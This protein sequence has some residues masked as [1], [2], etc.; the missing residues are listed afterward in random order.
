M[1]SRYSWSN[2]LIQRQ[3]GA[4]ASQVLLDLVQAVDQPVDLLGDGV[5][6]EARARGRG[7]AEAS[8]QR[9]GAVVAGADGD[10]LPVED[11]RDVVRMDPGD[12]ERDDPGTPLDG[13]PEDADPVELGELGQRVLGQLVLVPLDRVEADLVEVVDRDAEAVGLRN[14]GCAGLELVRQ[15]VPAR[16]VE[17][18]GA[19]HLAAEVERRHLL[20]QLRPAPE[21]ARPRSVHRA[22]ATRSRGSRSRAPARRS[23]GVARPGP[24]RRP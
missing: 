7:D 6:V 17:R 1:T 22:C 11:L 15:L 9:L 24:R 4:G 16:A 14:R 12:V 19:D 20:E 3:N 21:R 2:S 23:P 8:H 5:E 10:A 18:D 13:R